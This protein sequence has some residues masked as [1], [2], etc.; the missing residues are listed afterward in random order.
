MAI[1]PLRPL[2]EA[3]DKHGYGQGAFNV[4]AVAQAKAV[5]AVHELAAIVDCIERGVKEVVGTLIVKFGSVGRAPLVEQVTL[6][7]MAERYKKTGI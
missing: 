6:E 5:I 4:N 3:A 1:L 2:L 7:E